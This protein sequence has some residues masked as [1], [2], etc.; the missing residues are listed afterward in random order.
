MTGGGVDGGTLRNC[1][2]VGNAALY[3]GGGANGG[4]LYN[5]IVYHNSAGNAGPEVMGTTLNFCCVSSP[6]A[7][8]LG[9]ITNTP[10][11]V[12]QVNGDLSLSSSSPCI[13]SGRNAYE[14]SASDLDG[15]PRIAGGTVDIGAYECPAPSS[16]L[17]YA[18]AQRYGIPTDGS[19]DFA[20]LDGDEMSNWQESLAG[21]NPTHAASAF[22][23]LSIE[24]ANN[25]PGIAVSWQSVIGMSYFVQRNTNPVAPPSF[26][27]LQSNVAGSSTTTVFVDTNAPL[28]GG[29]LYRVGLQP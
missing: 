15:N 11:F 2:L 5:C 29:A 18:W 14:S 6:P 17:S 4:Q 13:N 10:W 21:T 27:T 9:N 24:P 7:N 20:D 23:L 1:T 19:A 26:V 16:I 12:D 25:L 3:Q 22:K 8:G 28:S